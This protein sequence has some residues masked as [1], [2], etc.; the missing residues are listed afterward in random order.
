MNHLVQVHPKTQ[1]DHGDLQQQLG[2]R[3]GLGAIRVGD[4]EAERDA[5]DQ[6]DRR[7]NKSA[8][9]QEQAEKKDGF[10][11]EGLRRIR[12]LGDLSYF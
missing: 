6:R 8:G 5:A 12:Q 9:G 7:R 3:A 4:G 1:Q 2:Q 10:R 11:I